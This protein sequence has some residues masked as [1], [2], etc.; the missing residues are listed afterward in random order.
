MLASGLQSKLEIARIW[1]RVRTAMATRPARTGMMTSAPDAGG[2]PCH[3]GAGSPVRVVSVPVSLVSGLTRST[4][5]S[6]ASQ[7]TSTGTLARIPVSSSVASGNDKGPRRREPGRR[8]GHRGRCPR[9]ARDRGVHRRQQGRREP[10]IGLLPVQGRPAVTAAP[11][12]TP[13]SMTARASRTSASLLSTMSV[14][15]AADVT[16]T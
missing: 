8:G 9:P 5:L 3:S 1:I 14:I 13:S 12:T 15:T 2:G 10:G 11:S 4:S 7:A 6:R 16:E